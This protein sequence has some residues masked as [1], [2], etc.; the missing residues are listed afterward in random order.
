MVSGASHTKCQRTGCLSPP[1][2]QSR[3][4]E[5]TEDPE[6]KRREGGHA[7]LLPPQRQMFV[8]QGVTCLLPARLSTEERRCDRWLEPWGTALSPG[9]MRIFFISP[10][11]LILIQSRE[12]ATSAFQILFSFLCLNISQDLVGIQSVVLRNKNHRASWERQN[13][14]L[15]S[16][17]PKPTAST[18][19]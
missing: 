10:H 18:I 12:K 16:L 11:I 15:P 9:A 14:P 13:L 2:V 7:S 1:K 4:K 3:P 19:D 17:L 8:Y 6:D 5:I